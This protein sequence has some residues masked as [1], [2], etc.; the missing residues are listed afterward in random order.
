[1]GKHETKDTI[2]RIFMYMKKIYIYI[3][4][5]GIDHMAKVIFFLSIKRF[6]LE[7]WHGALDTKSIHGLYTLCIWVDLGLILRQCQ[8]WSPMNLYENKWPLRSN[9]VKN[10]TIFF[11]TRYDGTYE[12]LCYFIVALIGPSI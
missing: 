2:G 3:Y 9:I 6:D 4:I 7:T 5:N 12:R 8:I 1:M 11:T 10:L